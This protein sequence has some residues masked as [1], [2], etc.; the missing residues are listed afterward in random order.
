M[1]IVYKNILDEI[2]AAITAAEESLRV[3][4]KI[5]LTKSEFGE[6][7]KEMFRQYRVHI[8]RDHANM[9]FLGVKIEVE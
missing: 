4:E 3:V 1:R 2:E 7:K 6:F 8:Y 5:V 9:R